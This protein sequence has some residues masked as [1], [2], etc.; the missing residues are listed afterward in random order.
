MNY[1]TW[2]ILPS[3]HAHALHSMEWMCIGEQVYQNHQESISK[4]YQNSN[5][6][7]WCNQFKSKF[8]IPYHAHDW[9]HFLIHDPCPPSVHVHVYKVH[10]IQWNLHQLRTKSAL[11]VYWK[12]VYQNHSKIQ[13]KTI[14]KPYRSFQPGCL[15]FGSFGNTCGQPQETVWVWND[16]GHTFWYMTHAYLRCIAFN[17]TCIMYQKCIEF[18]QDNMKVYQTNQIRNHRNP[19]QNQMETAENMFSRVGFLPGKRYHNYLDVCLRLFSLVSF[20][21]P[22]ARWGLLDFIRAVLLLLLG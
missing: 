2:P 3:V 7:L 1:D 8:K 12:Q 21:S 18:V 5:Q 19:Y 20:Y 4:L 11:N 6:I 10:Y 15:I 16:F 13:I 17:G 22:P 9:T 14:S